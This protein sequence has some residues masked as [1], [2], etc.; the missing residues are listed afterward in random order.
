MR[1][2]VSDFKLPRFK[3]PFLD[4]FRLRILFRGAFLLLI[5]ATLYLAMFILQQE[6]QLAY[7]N[8][9]QN[10]L[11]T[12]QQ[13]IATL[14]HPNGQ[15]ALLN[16]NIN[17]NNSPV[18]LPFASVD[19]DDQNKVQQAMNMA[20]CMEQYKNGN[21]LCVGVG[22]NP[23]AGGFIYVVGQFSE[24]D[25][26]SHTP[27]ELAFN[28]SHR[29]AINVSLRGNTY[30]WLAPFEETSSKAFKN[31]NIGVQGRLTGFNAADV[32]DG[33]VG[34]EVRP[35]KEFRGWL[36]Q[37]AYCQETDIEPTS[38]GCKKRSYFSVR[39]PIQV[40]QDDL[41]ASKQA[42]NV[43]P[44]WPP[45]DLSSIKVAVKVLAPPMDYSISDTKLFDS[46][47][48]IE[49]PR[50]ALQDLKP[51]LLA[52]ETLTISSNNTQQKNIITGLQEDTQKTSALLTTLIEWLPVDQD[53][54]TKTMQT[55]AQ[56]STE[57]DTFDLSLTG[58]IQSINQSLSVVASRVA[59]YVGAMLIAIALIWLLIEIGI[60]RRIIKLTK[61]AA[62]LSNLVKNTNNL[63]QFQ[64]ADMR[65]VDEIG[66]LSSCLHDLLQRVKGDVERETIRV[67]QERDMWNAVGHEIMSPLQS[68][69]A[70]H[71]QPDDPSQR[72]IN[73]M[74][75]AIRVLYGS[76][77]PSEA[78]E[79]TQLQITRIDI[80]A[81][82]NSVANNAASAGIARVIFNNA[83]KNAVP[84][85]APIFVNADEYSLEDVITHVL[86]NADRFRVA[87]SVITMQLQASENAVSITIHNSGPNIAA[88]FMDKIFEY[89]VSDQLDAAA[90]GNRG[91]GLFVAKTYLAKMGG[92]ISVQNTADGVNF[93]LSL[94]RAMGV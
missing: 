90:V 89:G 74:Q 11:K 60:I 22:N 86:K 68:L 49:T 18:L 17:G 40:L 6:K 39:L 83:T 64:L 76:A 36:W 69:I 94:Q 70:L 75:Q 46:N 79:T 57:T 28:G 16:P 34:V 71:G 66:V 33:T 2:F 7:H 37:N 47:D 81:F 25:L 19:F 59:W 91:Q 26:V 58:N 20:G 85:F 29:V 24:A 30:S 77:S 8:Y 80:V 15:L 67:A 65:G 93:I 88:E 45:A 21:E 32:V 35:N 9:Q 1:N 44:V 5:A 73:R 14:R 53:Y 10:F 51:L 78:F 82:L 84:R 52:G 41:F 43:R 42:K 31:T 54:S 27:G 56:I 92:T 23:W 4:A 12:K 61:R 3:L 72:Y 48:A 62:M 13:I 50:F 63:A 55:S 87:N 38:I